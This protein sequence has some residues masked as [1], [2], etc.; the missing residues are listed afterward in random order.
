MTSL[1]L[2]LL[3]WC[4]TLSLSALAAAALWRPLLVLLGELC[5]TEQRS[6]FWTIWSVAMVMLVPLLTVSA[7]D[8]EGDAVQVLRGIIFYAVGGIVLALLGMGYAVWTRTPRPE[9]NHGHYP[10]P[11]HPDV[12]AAIRR[13]MP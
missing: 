9:N 4:I 6:R 10:E 8:L 11:V 13:E 7:M 2:T 12:V 5:G 3:G 1:S